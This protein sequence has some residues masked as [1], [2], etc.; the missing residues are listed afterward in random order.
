MWFAEQMEAKLR[1]NDH[2]GGW[3]NCSLDWLVGRLYREA[4]ELWIEVDRV[5]PEPERIIREA[6]DV[7][8]FAMMIADIAR[9]INA[10]EKVETEE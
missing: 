4:K 6:A 8:N 5:V 9:R 10:P 2:K 3:E 7:A 1:E